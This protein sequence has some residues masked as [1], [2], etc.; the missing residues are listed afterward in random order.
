[1]NVTEIVIALLV[2]IAS[3]AVGYFDALTFGGSI[4]VLNPATAFAAVVAFVLIVVYDKSYGRLYE[5]VT[6]ASV[7]AAVVLDA[8]RVISLTGG[9]MVPKA[10]KLAL[11]W[12]GPLWIETKDIILFATRPEAIG[13]EAFTAKALA[14][15]PVPFIVL[16]Y[17]FLVRRKS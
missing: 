17:Y 16:G 3:V 10:L 8:L 6:K 9:L 15:D 11:T 2:V 1:V 7:L 4:N 14:L 12:L 5:T 13:P